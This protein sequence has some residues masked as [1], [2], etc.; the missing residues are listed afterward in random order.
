MIKGREK[1]HETCCTPPNDNYFKN[2][3]PS[4]GQAMKLLKIPI[5]NYHLG[6]IIHYTIHIII[7][8][9][10]LKIYT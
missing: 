1:L 8:Y 4:L 9:I 6:G 5:S 7:H 3:V 10:L 2:I